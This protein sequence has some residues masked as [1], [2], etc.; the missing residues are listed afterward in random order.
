MNS[1]FFKQNIPFT[2]ADISE[3]ICHTPVTKIHLYVSIK[4]KTKMMGLC[5]TFTV[6]AL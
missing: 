4:N 5:S 6:H 2:V 3:G 1:I